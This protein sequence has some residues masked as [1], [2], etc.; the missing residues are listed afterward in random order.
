MRI[1]NHKPGS[2]IIHVTE[3][4]SKRENRTKQKTNVL[5]PR[6]D[7]TTIMV[8]ILRFAHTHTY[9]QKNAEIDLA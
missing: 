6:Y 4:E 8:M 3:T 7:P 1:M 9:T 5:H 2:V